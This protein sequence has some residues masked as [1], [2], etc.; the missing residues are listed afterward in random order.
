V[1]KHS[2]PMPGSGSARFAVAAFP[3]LQ[4][5]DIEPPPP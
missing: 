2:T 5:L 3:R 4:L 1:R